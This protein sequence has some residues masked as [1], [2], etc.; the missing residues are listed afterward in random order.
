MAVKSWQ[1]VTAV[2]VVSF[3]LTLLEIPSG[4][5]FTTA[6]LSLACGVAALSLMGTAAILGG[7]WPVLESV[8]GGLDRVYEVH[9]WLAVFALS[10]ASVHLL[11]K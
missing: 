6:A 2:I 11:F 8:F 1:A 9:K 7:R 10:L 4:T 5:W 3:G